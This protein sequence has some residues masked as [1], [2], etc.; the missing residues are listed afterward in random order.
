M[1]KVIS[2]LLAFALCLT[3]WACS[4]GAKSDSVSIPENDSAAVG[5]VD[6]AEVLMNSGVTWGPINWGGFLG[7][8]EDGVTIDEDCTWALEDS[9]VTITN[10]N[11]SADSYEITELNGAYYLVGQRYTFYSD[12]FVRPNEI[13]R[14]SVEITVD[15]WQ[16]YFELHYESVER[17]DQ[18]GE[19]TGEVDEY[20]Q[21]RLKDT[22][23][24]VWLCWDSE[25]LLRYTQNGNEYD[26]KINNGHAYVSLLN[27]TEYPLEMVKI[28]GTL[29]FVDGL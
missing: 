21:L 19:S 13:P 17:F 25:V 20:Y 22:Y 14:K 27:F 23:S 9:V 2:L 12:V 11:G 24:R 15:N 18:F 16:E 6:Y 10:K 26:A 7:F 28:Q 5:E 4:N 1:K 29:Y 3:L 8:L